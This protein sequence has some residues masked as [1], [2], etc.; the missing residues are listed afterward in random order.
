MSIRVQRLFKTYFILT[1]I[2]DIVG[3]TGSHRP[4]A[5][6]YLVFAHRFF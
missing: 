6:Y 4:A 5:G 2:V 1:D 3:P